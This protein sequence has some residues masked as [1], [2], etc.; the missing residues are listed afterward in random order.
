MLTTD[1][2]RAQLFRLV[3]IARSIAM[4]RAMTAV[5]DSPRLNFWRLIFG[6]QL[7]VAV[8]EWCKV[9]GSDAEATHWKKAVNTSERSGYRSGLLAAI[10]IDELA[11]SDYWEKMKAYRDS[12]VAH[13][14]ENGA[15]ANYPELEIA[16]KSSAFHYKHVLS[17]LRERGQGRYPDD[18]MKYYTEFEAQSFQIARAAFAAT[19]GIEESVR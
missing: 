4:K 8:L 5:C 2:L 1:E 9:F 17:Q 15:V 19:A 14:V 12:F 18:L 7:D 6:S 13:H 11:W 16:L 10:E 3:H